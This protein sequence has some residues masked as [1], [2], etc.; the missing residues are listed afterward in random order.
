MK[1][2]IRRGVLSLVF[3]S[4]LI[5]SS[6]FADP[7]KP[8]VISDVRTIEYSKQDLRLNDRSIDL[9]ISYQVRHSNI[10]DS[11]YESHNPEHI[12]YVINDTWVL[13]NQ[14]LR[15]KNISSRDC[16]R[17]YNLNIFIL[18]TE[19]LFDSERF[20]AFF[21]E[22]NRPSSV[23]YGYYDSTVEIEKNS[24][25]L[26]TNV[27][28]SRNDSVFAHELA[29]YWWDRLCIANHWQYSSENFALRFQD[30]YEDRR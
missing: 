3:L 25:I 20:R 26:L 7:Y 9:S 12:Y 18:G 13:L 29:H 4:C 5:P 15:S 1:T 27:G 23:L 19:I 8:P 28:R 14:F 6:V 16:R 10:N 30:Y 24:V 17:D 2:L 22:K 11:L 21:V